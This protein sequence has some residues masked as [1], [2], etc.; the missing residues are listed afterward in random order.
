[1]FDSLSQQ[2]WQA[3]IVT[4]KLATVT[5]LCL[6]LIGLPLAWRLAQARSGWKTWAQ[7]IIALP[8]VLPPTVLG[9]Y[10][11][12]LL[13]PDGLIGQLASQLGVQSL[14]FSFGGIVFASCIYSLPFVVQPL[15]NHF[16]N[17][18]PQIIET[19]MTLGASRLD[20]MYSIILPQSRR[21][22]LSAGVLG[23]AHTLGE[24]GVILMVGGKIP[25]ETRVVS[26]QIYEHVES[27]AYPQAH[28]LSLILL[29]SALITLLLLYSFD[30]QRLS[31]LPKNRSKLEKVRYHD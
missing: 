30:Q 7:S 17:I 14:A 20:I 1:M 23:F 9:F 18:E 12:L 22:I 3:I 6:L 21:A 19:A 26:M 29:I 4:L 25:G 15:I 10:C 24:F 28:S 27:L 2:D 11:L 13:S 5:T 31:M 8:L 16:E